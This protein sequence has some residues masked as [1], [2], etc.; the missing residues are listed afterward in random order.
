M[1]IAA[2]TASD[3]FSDPQRGNELL[4]PNP[5]LLQDADESSRLEL[6]MVG[7]DTPGASAAENHVAAALAN[8][9]EPKP[10]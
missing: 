2:L 7:D 4:G 8:E 6:A 5:G 3:S 1:R 9:R 10:L